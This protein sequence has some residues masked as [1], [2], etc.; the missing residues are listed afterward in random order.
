MY[1]HKN[2]SREVSETPKLIAFVGSDFYCWKSIKKLYKR[3]YPHIDFE[4]NH[5]NLPSPQQKIKTL[6]HA[7]SLKKYQI[8][9]LEYS[10]NIPEML[11]LANNIRR[12]PETAE[13]VVVALFEE[14]GTLSAKQTLAINLSFGIYLNFSKNDDVTSVATHPMAIA[15][16]N[17]NIDTGYKIVRTELPTEAVTIFKIGYYSENYLHLECDYDFKEGLCVKLKTT[18][19]STIPITNHFIV[20]RK[21]DFNLYSNFKYAYDFE[22][23]NSLHGQLSKLDA[24]ILHLEQKL[25]ANPHDLNIKY[26]LSDAKCLRVSVY[27]LSQSELQERDASI[28]E[29]IKLNMP[30]S[31]SKK[32]RLLIFDNKMRF[33]FSEPGHMDEFPFSCRY[34]ANPVIGE[35]CIFRR[36]DPS[37]VAIQLDEVN[38]SQTTV[39][40]MILQIKS[41][42]Q[43]QPFIIIFNSLECSDNLQKKFSYNSILATESDLNFE[44]I[45]QAMQIFEHKMGKQVTALHPINPD[46]ERRFYVSKYALASEGYYSHAITIRALSVTDIIFSC[47]DKIPLNTSFY[48]KSPVKM[49]VTITN[50]REGKRMVPENGEYYGLISGV[51][52]QDTA[53]LKNYIHELMTHYNE[54][55]KYTLRYLHRN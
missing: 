3:N 14:L 52:E 27:E 17:I 5:I 44:F 51:T 11:R 4:F 24:K 13:A 12:A 40:E 26:D 42:M 6:I 33:L 36:T 10:E 32:T 55:K 30:N 21:R 7:L 8:I 31:V 37:V 28:K 54:K 29:F 34:L 16:P 35:S 47:S 18:T 20:R 22:Y 43:K 41:N 48:I 15:F 1:S 53:T 2:V 39:S 25:S 38:I 46:A 49:T 23:D 9:Y 45:K 50:P 19:E